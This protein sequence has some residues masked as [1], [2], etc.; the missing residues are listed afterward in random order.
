MVLYW[1][2][3]ASVIGVANDTGQDQSAN[4]VEFLERLRSLTGRIVLN[5]G[6]Q[7]EY[8]RRCKESPQG[9]G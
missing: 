7:S 9:Q 5:S 8:W 1:V 3:D 4:A 6:I 2:V